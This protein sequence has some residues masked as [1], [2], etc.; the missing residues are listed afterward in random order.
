VDADLVRLREELGERTGDVRCRGIV[1]DVTGLDVMDSFTIRT[2]LDIA[3]VGKLRGADA[4]IVG[5][6][7]EVAFAMVQLGLRMENVA[8][9]LDVEE[10]RAR[11][12]WRQAPDGRV[13]D[14]LRDQQ[15]H[16]DQDEEMGRG[17]R[18]P[19]AELIDWAVAARPLPGQSCSGDA[20]VVAPFPEGVLIGVVDGLGHGEEA[21]AA[22]DRAVQ[23]LRTHAGEPEEM[24]V[25][26][27]HDA[28]RG[29]R[30]AVMSLVS[31]R[32][33]DGSMSWI[34]VGNVEAIIARPG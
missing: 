33:V 21:A 25:R 17:T 5:I 3:Q 16:D 12:P 14:L 20:H 28:L 31:I 9:A 27:C 7:P 19:A 13:R 24:L 1:V 10:P 18:A 34:G 2:L 32:P 8:T 30:G 15:G 22:S 26:H 23:T 6:Q 29:T 11:A 4:V